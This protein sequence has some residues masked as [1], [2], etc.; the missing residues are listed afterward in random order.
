MSENQASTLWGRVKGA[1]R[2]NVALISILILY[3]ILA[4]AYSVIVPLGEAPDEVPHFTYI[5]YIT[6]HG[7]LPVG[8]EEH[9]GFQ[10]P[11]YYLI[12]AAATSWIDTEDYAIRANGDYSFT[13]DRPPFNL[14]LHTTAESF[15]YRGWALAWHLIRLL[16][17]AMGATTVWAT[18]RIAKEIFPA[19]EY[20]AVGA[21]AFNAFLPQ[22]LFISGVVNNDN[23]A[24][25]LSSLALLVVV[26][27]LKGARLYRNFLLLGALVGLGVL[28][29]ASLLNFFVIV[30]IVIG[31][32]LWQER[33]EKG[34]ALLVRRGAILLGLVVVPFLLIAGWWFIRNQILYG[35]PLGW[36][37]VLAANALR[38]APLTLGDIQ[39]LIWGLYRSFWLRWIGIE[40]E[41]LFYAGL[42]IP[43]VLAFA[44]LMTLFRTRERIPPPAP[45]FLSVLGLYIIMVAGSLIPW[46]A[47][48][49]GTDQARLLYPAVSAI[50]IFMFLG[51]AQLVPRRGGNYLA[52]GVAGGML[53]F[54]IV[55]P[56]RYIM[57]VHAPPPVLAEQ[58]LAGVQFP[59]NINFGDK[60]ELVGYEVNRENWRPGDDLL[61]TMYWEALDDLDEDYWLLMRLVHRRGWDLV[62]KDG[63]PSAGRYT[64]DFWKKGDIIPSVHRL[65]I[66]EDAAQHR[67]RLTLSVHPF[68]SEDWLPILNEQDQDTGD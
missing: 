19:Y 25:T 45:L 24:T 63:C 34:L 42:T 30:I 9:E 21:A 11:L 1:L 50:A 61:V 68:E 6:L 53:V 12:G 8:A 65:R 35:D 38:E 48:V 17:V 67:Y 37:L 41:L 60:I 29:K 56:V 15:P 66:P 57:P 4:T 47:T 7:N 49:L 2:A 33:R 64:T 51:W 22:F 46:T 52:S 23:L 28:A 54:A 13:E 5:R 18:Y 27:I 3:V 31:L 36:G 44:G 62:F 39:W 14:L 43:C 59:V 20:I 26:K 40:L 58:D 55:A 16:S 10:P 32:V